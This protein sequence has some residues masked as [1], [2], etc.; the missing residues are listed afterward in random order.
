MSGVTVLVADDHAPVR[1]GVR[2][3][4][5]RGG[6]TVCAE[7][8]DAANAVRLALSLRPHVC[9]LD[10]RMPGGGINAARTIADSLPH[11]AVVMLTISDDDD[12]LFGAL[13]AGASGYLLKD[14][15]PD[16]LPLALESV[17]R[18]EAALPPALVTRLVDA[19][20]PGSGRRKLRLPGRRAA[21]LTRREHEVLGL[22][23][24]GLTTREIAARLVV[25]PVTVRTHVAALLRKLGAASRAEALRLLD[26]ER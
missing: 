22:L 4:L 17:L 6:L 15:D 11:T 16:Q 20:H 14:V 7:A 1:A 8:A 19:Y 2:R 18:G 21:E 23:R 9:L 24:E 26:G 25:E 5:E 10:V 12:D 3:A 13:S